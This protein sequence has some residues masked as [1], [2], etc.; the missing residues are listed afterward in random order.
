M[1]N[2]LVTSYVNDEGPF[3]L[4]REEIE[5]EGEDGAIPCGCTH[6][7]THV[8]D[9]WSGFFSPSASPSTSHT[10]LLPSL[11]IHSVEVHVRGGGVTGR[12]REVKGWV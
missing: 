7:H 5:A 10:H 9:R 12:Q 8:R 6:P 11:Q 3:D 2:F 1:A 4:L